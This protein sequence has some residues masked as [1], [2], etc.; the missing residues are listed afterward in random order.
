MK[1]E[2]NNM[3]KKSQLHNSLRTDKRV[4]GR[5]S[6]NHSDNLTEAEI[7]LLKKQGRF[8]SCKYQGPRED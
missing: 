6:G 1:G 3:G 4:Y 2:T 7:K 5:F 8:V